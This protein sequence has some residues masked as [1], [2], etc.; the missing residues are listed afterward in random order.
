MPPF[1]IPGK[2]F[3]SRF[4]GKLRMGFINV[5]PHLYPLSFRGRIEFF[6]DLVK[7]TYNLCNCESNEATLLI[8]IRFGFY[9]TTYNKNVEKKDICLNALK[10]L[11]DIQGIYFL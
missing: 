3:P 4:K 8:E 1:V 7:E 2:N 5:T 6:S 9:P 11:I 10:E